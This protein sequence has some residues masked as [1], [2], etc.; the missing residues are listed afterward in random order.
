M[1]IA[2]LALPSMKYKS[3]PILPSGLSHQLFSKIFK[4]YI[5]FIKVTPY[6]LVIVI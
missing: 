1:T 4:I 2:Q 5:L 3:A 6:Y